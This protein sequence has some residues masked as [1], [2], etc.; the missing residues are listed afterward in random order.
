MLGVFLAVL[1]AG[2]AAMAQDATRQTEGEETLELIDETEQPT[3]T[4]RKP[5]AAR[6][7]TERREGG[8]V[9]EVKVKTGVS[10]YYL[11]PNQSLGS[12]FDDGA[13]KRRPAMWR[14]HEFDVTGQRPD[15]AGSETEE[16][17]DYTS[18]APVPPTFP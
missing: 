18:D 13:S 2:P 14:I 15:Q 4:I 9:K 1:A 12:A 11:Y 7:I 16:A 17:F 5:D 6:E 3:I 10:T 8:E